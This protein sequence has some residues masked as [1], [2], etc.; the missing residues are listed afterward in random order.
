MALR[1]LPD[2]GQ[3][4]FDRY[5]RKVERALYEL[6]VAYYWAPDVAP[7]Y[8]PE[9]AGLRIFFAHRRWWATYRALEDEDSDWLPAADHQFLLRITYDPDEPVGVH[10]HPC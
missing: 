7:D 6:A 9:E 2:A 1:G 10:F 5:S 4:D 3:M 8:R